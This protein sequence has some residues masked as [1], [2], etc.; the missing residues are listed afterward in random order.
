MPAVQSSFFLLT[1]HFPGL[2]SEEEAADMYW[3]RADDVERAVSEGRGG[4]L[5]QLAEGPT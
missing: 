1:L 2:L 4:K 3:A 5:C